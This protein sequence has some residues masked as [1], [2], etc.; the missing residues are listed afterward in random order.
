MLYSDLAFT[1]EQIFEERARVHREGMTF[2]AFVSWQQLAAQSQNFPKW[3]E[4]LQKIGLTEKTEVS[5]E[6]LKREADDALRKAQ[7]ILKRGAHGRR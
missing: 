6:D 5:K 2:A 4:Y 3:G 1:G 7:N